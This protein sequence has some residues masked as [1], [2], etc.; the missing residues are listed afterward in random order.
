MITLAI[1]A[2]F[3]VVGWPAWAHVTILSAAII[4]GFALESRSLHKTIKAH[5]ARGIELK[6][7]IELEVFAKAV[8]Y[9]NVE[10]IKGQL[11]QQNAA[12]ERLK[13]DAE[14]QSQAA[15]LAAVRAYQKGRAEAERLRLPTSQVPSGAAGM[16]QW[17]AER[18]TR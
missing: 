6:R 11:Q 17:L 5:E 18:V 3:K 9:A 10:T 7:R 4:G 12:V 1:R 8:A 16:N 15:S 13:I 14:A 2:F